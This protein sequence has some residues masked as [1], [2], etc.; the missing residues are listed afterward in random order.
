VKERNELLEACKAIIECEG[1]E[2]MAGDAK[3]ALT[4]TWA[5]KYASAKGLAKAALAHAQEKEK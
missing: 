5:T 3:V 4:L 2:T 1:S